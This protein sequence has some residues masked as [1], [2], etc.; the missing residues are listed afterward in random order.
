MKIV[1][2]IKRVIKEFRNVNPSYLPDL[3]STWQDKNIPSKQAQVADRQIV[4]MYNGHP[5]KVFTVAARL[6]KKIP[7]DREYSFLDVACGYGYYNEVVSHLVPQ[8]KIAYTGGDFND[9]MLALAKQRYPDRHFQKEDIRALSMQDRFFDIVFSSAT[10]AHL[11]DYREGL[12]ELVR[13]CKLWVVLHRVG[14]AWRK[15]SSIEV[16]HHYDVDVYVNHISHDELL[17]MMHA[18][19][20]VLIAEEPLWGKSLAGRQGMSFLF[21]RN[22]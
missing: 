4:E 12:G 8:L 19:G 3:T 5:P 22:V 11:K 20:F 2:R 6:L 13:V 10:L 14:I 15:K 16:Q 1:Q 17:R 21:Q 18:M 9:E 7:Q